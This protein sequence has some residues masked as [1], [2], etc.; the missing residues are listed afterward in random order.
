MST[1]RITFDRTVAQS[2]WAD[3]EAG[4]EEEAEEKAEALRERIELGEENAGWSL[5]EQDGGVLVADVQLWK[6]E[7]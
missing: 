3:I 7:S 6:E 5:G 4:S 1:Y 2:A